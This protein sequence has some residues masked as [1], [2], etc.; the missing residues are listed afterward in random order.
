MPNPHST[1]STSVLASILKNPARR[2]THVLPQS[3]VVAGDGQGFL[4]FERDLQ[5]LARQALSVRTQLRAIRRRVPSAR[6]AVLLVFALVQI[7]L[8]GRERLVVDGGYRDRATADDG[9][10]EESAED[11]KLHGWMEVL[12]RR[13]EVGT[14][15][16]DCDRLNGGSRKV[17]LLKYAFCSMEQREYVL[18]SKKSHAEEMTKLINL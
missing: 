6:V 8:D 18:Q 3:K 15:L 4:A 1:P 2:H 12:C 13:L 9:G 7:G 16:A 5:A 10:A 14:W 17:C 11:G